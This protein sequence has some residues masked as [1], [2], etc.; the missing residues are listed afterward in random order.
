[1]IND[2]RYDVHSANSR[3]CVMG[4]SMLPTF[5]SGDEVIVDKVHLDALVPG[6]CVYITTG[7]QSYVHRYLGQTKKGFLTKG[8]GHHTFDP[9]W[10]A[11]A[12]RGRVTEAWRN[13]KC[14]YKRTPRT[15]R[16]HRLLAYTHRTTGFIWTNLMRLKTALTALLFCL[17]ISSL[18]MGA[19]TLAHFELDPGPQEI[20]VYWETASEVGNLGFYLWRS[21]AELTGYYKLPVSDPGLQFI[22]SIDEGAGAFYEYVDDEATPGALY[23]YK[24]QDVPDTGA[25]GEYSQPLSGG[26]GL[27][28]A[29]LTLTPSPTPTATPT[30]N[31]AQTPTSTPRP[32]D[33]SVLFWTDTEQLSAGECATLQW[34]TANVKA[35]FL[36]GEGV[37]GVGAKAFCPCADETHTL[38]VDFRDNSR[39]AYSVDLS[40]SGECDSSSS[41]RTA[42]PTPRTAQPTENAPT[43]TATPQLI[44]IPANGKTPVPTNT[45]LVTQTP[46][47]TMT[48]A[49]PDSPEPDLT[50]TN[51]VRNTPTPTRVIVQGETPQRPALAKSTALIIFSALG[52][53]ALIGVGIWIWRRR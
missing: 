2:I 45:M 13:T 44:D 9:V 6:D 19:V 11:G 53:F 3:Y 7:N 35:V 30:P 18:V 50:S 27:A 10:T 39:R 40:V 38:T 22:P 46:D 23:Y 26:I 29:T 20:Y 37:A 28:T 21:E 42:T 8:D 17:F 51:I 36:N 1:M 5:Q 48:E 52:G 32:A 25:E 47:A 14:I 16:R 41:T 12:I 43:I 49:V 15:I 34:Q 33:P 24:L 31:V 4:D